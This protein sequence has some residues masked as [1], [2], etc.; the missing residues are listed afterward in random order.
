MS[1]P[2][3]MD[4][5]VPYAITTSL[6]LRGV[7]VLTAQQDGA[8][9]LT[10]SEL[11]SRAGALR[12]VLFSQDKDFLREATRRQKSGERFTGV[13]Y[14]HQLMVTIGQCV[15]DLELISQ[16]SELEDWVNHVEHLPLR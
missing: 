16:A 4:V 6:R 5:N 12:R 15:N 11:L 14:A 10:D 2:F 9:K 1:L 7:D 13:I 3:Y 8:H